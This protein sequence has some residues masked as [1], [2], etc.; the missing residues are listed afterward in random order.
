MDAFTLIMGLTLAV[1]GIFLY[2]NYA[3]FLRGVYAK[4]ARVISIQQVFTSSLDLKKNTSNYVENGFYPVIEYFTEGEPVRFTA[5]DPHVAGNLHVGDEVKL[6]VLKTRRSKN[7][8]CKTVLVLISMLFLLGF[9]LFISAFLAEAPL[10]LGQVCLASVIIAASLSTL[11]LYLKDQDELY[12]DGLTSTKGGRAQLFLAE[13]AAFKNW[14]S[15][16]TDPAQRYKIRSTQLF[17]ATCMGSSLVMI[18][19]AVQPMASYF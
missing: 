2:R 3:S 10:P 17:G 9:D 1:V 16:L 5:I 7:R 6:R 18:A 4:H 14:T 11:V 12:E 13:P 8:V 15:A 19:L